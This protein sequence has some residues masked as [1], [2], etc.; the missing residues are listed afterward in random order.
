MMSSANGAYT[1]ET[2]VLRTKS[3]GPFLILISLWPRII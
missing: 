2:I 1:T 3:P